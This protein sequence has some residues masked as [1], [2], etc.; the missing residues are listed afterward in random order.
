MTPKRQRLESLA[1]D[2]RA[3]LQAR[4]RRLGVPDSEVEDAVQDVLAVLVRRFDAVDPSRPA[5]PWL[6]G[7]ARRIAPKYRARQQVAE[8]VQ[9]RVRPGQ[10]ARVAL[11]ELLGRLDGPDLELFVLMD[12]QGFTAK[13]AGRQLGFNPNTVAY[14]VRRA[15]RELDRIIA[16]ERLQEKARMP[17]LVPWPLTATVA[18]V[19]LG[20]ATLALWRGC[21]VSGDLEETTRH[22]DTAEVTGKSELSASGQIPA[23]GKGRRFES[24][25]SQETPFRSLGKSIAIEGASKPGLDANDGHHFITERFVRIRGAEVDFRARFSSPHE[26]REM[27]ASLE[28]PTLEVTRGEPE[29]SYIVRPGNAVVHEVTVTVEETGVHPVNFAGRSMC[30]CS[31]DDLAYECPGA[32]V[33][34]TPPSLADYETGVLIQTTHTNT[35]DRP[36][37]LYVVAPEGRFGASLRPL[38]GIPQRLEPG[39]TCEVQVDSGLRFAHFHEEGGTVRVSADEDTVATW[40]CTGVS[41]EQK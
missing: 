2:Q 13:E 3:F 18:A 29:R 27:S 26:V 38:E 8:E 30:L 1:Q 28:A 24:G 34:T 25:R 19:I 10:E 31:E 35:C 21:G 15:R 11:N 41:T 12:V 4:L 33:P 7:V 40:R 32:C 23:K 37:D 17:A 20:A 6:A 22:R 36:I 5:R 9:V 14:R 16:R 39:E